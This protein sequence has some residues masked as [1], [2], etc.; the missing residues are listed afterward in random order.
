MLDDEDR[1]RYLMESV[2]VVELLQNQGKEK[3]P[4]LI[5]SHRSFPLR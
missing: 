2:D 4:R 5:L 3:L 1:I